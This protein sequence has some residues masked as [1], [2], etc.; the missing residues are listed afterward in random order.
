METYSFKQLFIAIMRIVF[1]NNYNRIINEQ[2]SADSTGPLYSLSIPHTSGFVSIEGTHDL[3]K[4][5]SV[6]NSLPQDYKEPFFMHVSGFKCGEIAH[7]LRLPLGIVK[8]RI[9][10]TCKRLQQEQKELV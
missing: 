3:E 7:K 2:A 4:V 10:F 8:S 5:R 6:V 9:F 1:L